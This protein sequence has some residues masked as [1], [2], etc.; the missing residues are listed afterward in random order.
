MHLLPWLAEQGYLRPEIDVAIALQSGAG[1]GS[2]IATK[3]ATVSIAPGAK[4]TE[5]VVVY[6]G[7]EG[8]TDADLD[9]ALKTSGATERVW[10]SPDVA[11]AVV[12]AAYRRSGYLSA[13]ATVDELRIDGSRAELP[14]RIEEGPRF[15]A[16]TV[17][18]DGVG[19]VADVDLTPPIQEEAVLTDRT[20]AEAVRE[21]ERKFRRAGYR[22]TRVTAES[23][24]RADG[25]TVDLVFNV[26][27]GQRARLQ[28]IRVA[29]NTDTSQALIERTIDIDA[30]EAASFDRINR[31]RDRL[32][33][34]G[35]F[36]TVTLETEPIPN[37]DGTPNP[38]VLRA[39]V[40]VEELP[41]YRLRYGFQLFDPS[42]PLFDPKWGKVD[43]GVVADLT[44]RGLFGRGL[45]GGLGARLN[46]SE[47]TIRGYIGSRT[48]FGFPAQTNVVV[49]G[50]DQKTVSAGLVLDSRSQTISF[51]QRI[52]HRRLL[53]VAY[54]YSFETRTFDFLAQLPMLPAP[55]PVQVE[56]NIGRLLGSVVVDDRDNV[57][58]T[59][60]GPF[61]SSTF[62]FAPTALGSTRGFRKYLGQQFYFVP[63]KRVTLAAA[64]RFEFSGGPGR[65]LVTTERLRVGGA[66]TV[67]GY[68]DDTLS[69]R[70][71]TGTTEGTTSIV[72]LN[73]EIRFPLTARLQGAAFWDYAHIYGETGDFTGL[74]V[75]NSLGAGVRL[76]LPFIIVRVDYGYPLNQD[77]RN[78]KGRWYFAIGQAF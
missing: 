34:T 17:A 19:A 1:S 23:T 51:D 62:E 42:S 22:G 40:T 37:A 55:I 30:G 39:N 54:G 33:D 46:P 36:R 32:Y 11:R 2:P 8:L 69:L 10:T 60:Q 48:F 57:V 50:E 20:V 76:L 28:E 78:D 70:D 65:G 21:L 53:Q 44:R 3:T 68:E 52:R 49:S 73:Q 61:H 31:A 16:G 14:I 38:G 5:R 6:T 41:K 43:P 58:N 27:L 45:V 35:L 13:Q 72:V 64:A 26:L 67:R 9:K 24:T 12:L 15:R 66:N 74:R 25:G 56:A 71:I 59:R 18:I 75:R 7:N 63:W 47:Q 29:G 4:S 77:F